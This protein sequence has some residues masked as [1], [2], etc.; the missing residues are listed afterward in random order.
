MSDQLNSLRLVD[1]VLTNVAR[2]FTNANF[3]GT[4]LFPIVPVSK[5]GGKIPQFSAEA[6]KVY[7]T[8]RAIRAK[9]NRISPLGLSSIDYVLEEHDLE[10]PMDYREISEDI[11]NLELHATFVVTE[12]IKLRL[13]KLIAD[14]S[15]NPANFNGNTASLSSADK[16]NNPASNPFAVIDS[17]RD[18]VRSK[19]AREPNTIVLGASAFNSLKNHPLVLDRIKYTQHSVLTEDLLKTLLNF[20][21]LFVGKAVYVN[22]SDT[23]VDVWSDTCILAY[24]PEQNQNVARN[25]YEPSFAYTLQKRNYPV[26]DKYTE[27]GKISVVRSTDIFVP[28]IVGPDAGYLLFDVNS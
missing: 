2:G 4:E 17:A 13:E 28:K 18:V 26:V 6:F 16:F 11:A 7:Q 10:Y 9:S 19:I 12:G 25:I 27:N 14:L 5:E 22:D 15:Q 1:E 3:I 8:E 24:V 21:N 23:F 20:K